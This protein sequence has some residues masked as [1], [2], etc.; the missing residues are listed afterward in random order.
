[1]NNRPRI[2]FLI[3]AM[4]LTGSIASAQVKV[5]GNVYGGGELGKVTENAQVKINDGTMEGSVYGGGQGTDTLETAGLV[6][7]NTTVH[8]KG[9]TV[10]RSI[11]GGGELGSVGTYTT[12]TVTYGAN[13]GANAG[14]RGCSCIPRQWRFGQSDC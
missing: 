6:Q 7:G 3:A 10:E 2:L 12:Q 5:K 14:N 11:Y 13:A 8:M 1:M 9:G 4:L